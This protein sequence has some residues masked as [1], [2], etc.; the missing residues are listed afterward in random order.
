[1][2]ALVFIAGAGE[3]QTA[4]KHMHLEAG[5]NAADLLRDAAGDEAAVSLPHVFYAIQIMKHELQAA[6]GVCRVIS[7]VLT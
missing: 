7:L 4:L 2:T 1:M 3:L 5:S 6:Q